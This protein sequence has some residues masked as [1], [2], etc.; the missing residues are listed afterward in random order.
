MPPRFRTPGRGPHRFPG[1]GSGKLPEPLRPD[2]DLHNARRHLPRPRLLT[3]MFKFN[4]EV[5]DPMTRARTGRMVTANGEVETPVFMPVGTLGAVKALSNEDL[6]SLDAQI[7]LGNTYHLVT[8]PG[9][10]ALKKAGGLHRF[11]GWKGPLLTDSGGYQ[12]FSLK[13]NRKIT[14]EGVRFQSHVNGDTLMFTPESVMEAEAIIGADIIMAF[15]ECAP[16]PCEKKAA[17]EAMSRTHRWLA[18]CVN[19][20]R[21]SGSGQALFGIIQGGVHDD[22]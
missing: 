12:V 20:H 9:L 17:A 4:A 14:E 10:D 6:V 8:R 16:F 2:A 18:R 15:D 13:E 1:R 7:I 21:D 5:Q 22:L 11:M 19:S 3:R